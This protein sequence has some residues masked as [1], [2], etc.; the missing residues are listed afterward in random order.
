MIENDGRGMTASASATNADIAIGTR[1]I[2]SSRIMGGS[3]RR[4]GQAWAVTW[5]AG[6]RASWRSPAAWRQSRRMAAGAGFGAAGFEG[7]GAAGAAAAAVEGGLAAESLV[8]AGTTPG[9]SQTN[10]SSRERS[11]AAAGRDLDLGQRLGRIA[12]HPARPCP[13]DSPTGKP[14]PRPD[15]TSKSPTCTSALVGR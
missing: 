9:L 1:R 4:Q 6:S 10:M 15:V 8:A 5:S 13:P 3:L 11:S 14:P 12:P 2:L 7:A